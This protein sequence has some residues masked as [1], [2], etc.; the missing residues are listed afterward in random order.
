MKETT[1]MPR[2]VDPSTSVSRSFSDT[3][4]PELTRQSTE[5]RLPGTASI[6]PIEARDPSST[7][8]S[9]SSKDISPA[10]PER[11]YP[12]AFDG[13]S[14]VGSVRGLIER[15]SK[16][17]ELALSQ[18]GDGDISTMASHIALVAA[19]LRKA[20][21]LT[22]F[23][24]ALASI[25]LFTCRATLTADPTTV[26]RAGL[27]SL[28]RALRVIS[29]NPLVDLAQSAS[30]AEDLSDAGWIGEDAAV[31]ALVSSFLQENEMDEG[32][33]RASSINPE[34][35]TYVMYD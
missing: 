14:L 29:D 12:H 11:L 27:N 6:T 10:S 16:D 30:I 8:G 31:A 5:T 9:F 19:L 3:I 25:L 28:V 2:K 13:N 24:D 22:N 26:T 7:R 20:Y 35:S 32:L 18:Y 15:S 34:K 21:E 33:A 23:N 17:A 1:E 4:L